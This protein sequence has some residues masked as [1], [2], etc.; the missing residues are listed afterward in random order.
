MFFCLQRIAYLCRRILKQIT[1]T[2]IIMIRKHFQWILAALMICGLAVTTTTSCSKDDDSGQ[3]GGSGNTESLKGYWFVQLNHV[4]D[5]DDGPIAGGYMEY[6]L[7]NFG[8]DGVVT[9]SVY[10]GNAGVSLEYWERMLRHGIYTVNEAAGT[11][12]IQN[13][14]DDET[15]IAKYSLSG[16]KLTLTSTESYE[17][18]L[19]ITFHRP[20]TEEL[21]RCSMYDSELEGDDYVGKWFAVSEH[22]GLY[23]YVYL[24]IDESS[25]IT[26]TR[27]SVYEDDV[28]RTSYFRSVSTLDE[29]DGERIVF[30]D[31]D[32]YSVT[33]SYVWSVTDNQLK[34]VKTEYEDL[35][36][37]YHPLTKSDI[38]LM[39]ELNKKA[40]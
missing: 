31:P 28:T 38:K 14:S 20:S 40:K 33:D 34:F 26:V 5:E 30:H 25:G 9:R 6:V 18:P 17:E 36:T 4:Y 22:N 7:L 37:V 3:Q 23:T 15:E 1:K 19:T 11:I 32:D 2:F 8:D 13:F 39:D 21:N 27:Y 29:E 12:T 16:D 35:Y 10:E 24:D